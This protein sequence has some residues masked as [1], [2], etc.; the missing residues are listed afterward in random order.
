MQPID[1]VCLP[2][3][4][5]YLIGG[6]IWRGESE[7]LFNLTRYDFILKQHGC[8]FILGKIEEIHYC[9]KVKPFFIH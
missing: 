5:Q 4:N 9:H 7:F 3:I 6:P 2:L 8:I 1:F